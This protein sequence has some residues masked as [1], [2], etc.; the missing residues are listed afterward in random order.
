MGGKAVA[1]GEKTRLLAGEKKTGG[2]NWK[3]R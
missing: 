3:G 1:L 2:G